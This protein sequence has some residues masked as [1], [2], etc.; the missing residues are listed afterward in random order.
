MEI[1]K[2]FEN[3]LALNEIEFKDVESFKEYT[4]NHK[5]RATT[6]VTIGGKKVKAGDAIK[7]ISKAEAKPKAAPKAEDESEEIKEPKGAIGYIVPQEGKDPQLVIFYKKYHHVFHEGDGW[8]MAG[9]SESG[10]EK[11]QPYAG[12]FMAAIAAGEKRMPGSADKILF[13]LKIKKEDPVDAARKKEM[14]SMASDYSPKTKYPPIEADAATEKAIEQIDKDQDLRDFL[15]NLVH[16]KSNVMANDGDNPDMEKVFKLTKDAK[17]EGELYR[18][19]WG[20]SPDDF[21]V[22]DVK[23][24]DRYQSFSETK[25]VALGFAGQERNQG[26]VF[27]VVNPKGGFNYAAWMQKNDKSLP[28]NKDDL[29]FARY[30]REHIFDRKQKYEV[31]KKEKEGP[32]TIVE[33]KFV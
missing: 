26:V 5:M 21:Q 30:E 28:V 15:A 20:A 4:K 11:I 3:W 23:T 7:A 1:V 2:L 33:I 19:M 31:V 12:S 17:Y 25:E 8:L 14:N 27:K 13:K 10:L 9:F 29:N 16:D 18:G 22:G 6:E 24:F 32:F